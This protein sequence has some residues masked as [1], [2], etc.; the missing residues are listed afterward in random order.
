MNTSD[1]SKNALLTESKNYRVLG[2]E[3]MRLLHG[4]MGLVTEAAEFMDALKKNIY[5]GKPT[6]VS[7]LEE[8]LGDILW[9]MAILCDTMDTDFSE[10]MDKNIA[11][12]KSR[13]PDRYSPDGNRFSSEKAKNRD[14]E[15]EKAALKGLD[16]ESKLKIKAYWAAVDSITN[17]KG[18]ICLPLTKEQVR[19][20]PNG[21]ELKP[22]HDRTG[23]DCPLCKINVHKDYELCPVCQ[24]SHPGLGPIRKPT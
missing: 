18:E 1:Y 11:K 10:L 7:N 16:K 24:E 3:D 8:E 5:Y 20:G 17:D 22:E 19:Y 4:A 15:D 23:W 21:I 12:L 6:D 2:K 9:Y 13:Y 14:L